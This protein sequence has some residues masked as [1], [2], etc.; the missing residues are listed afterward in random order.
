MRKQKFHVLSKSCCRVFEKCLYILK[1]F[2]RPSPVFYKSF[3]SVYSHPNKLKSR[4]SNHDK[5]YCSEMSAVLIAL[6]YVITFLHCTKPDASIIRK[7]HA[8]FEQNASKSSE[9]KLV[10]VGHLQ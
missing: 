5:S 10:K 7:L 1:Q 6:N 8:T 4:V 2:S 3:M 9:N